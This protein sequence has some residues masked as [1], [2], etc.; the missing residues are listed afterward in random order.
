LNDER[1]AEREIRWLT[2]RGVNCSGHFLEIVIRAEESGFG[3]RDELEDP[4]A[5][6]LAR[7]GGGSG[8]NVSNID[9]DIDD[10]ARGLSVIRDVLRESQIRPSTI[11]R[12]YQPTR[13]AY[14]VYE[15]HRR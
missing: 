4:L 13:I 6:A 2:G 1:V 5:D 3:G 11:I 10:L 15:W 12:Q 7:A 9:L 8:L 14:P